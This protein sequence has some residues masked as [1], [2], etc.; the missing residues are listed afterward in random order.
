MT[1]LMLLWLLL[2]WLLS[3]LLLRFWRPTTMLAAT[4][5]ARVG[6]SGQCIDLVPDDYNY[7]NNDDSLLL[8]LLLFF[9]LLFLLGWLMER[10]RMSSSSRA[11]R[12]IVVFARLQRRM[13][14]SFVP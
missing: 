7:Y 14:L 8:L 1:L 2:L 4:R 9:L 5:R 3:L 10:P 12:R 11:Y 13:H 6:K